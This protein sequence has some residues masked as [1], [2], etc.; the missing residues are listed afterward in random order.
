MDAAE[1]EALVEA[2]KQ[3]GL[4]RYESAVYLGLLMDETAKVSEI[5]KRTGVPQPKA[6]Q[7]LDSLVEKGFCTLG[8]DAI[9][10]Y[11]PVPPADALEEHRAELRR[12]EARVKALAEQLEEIRIAGQGRELWAPPIEII[13]GHPQVERLVLAR[14]AG[15]AEEILFFGKRP[16]MP[17]VD[18]SEALEAF[19]N[20]G[21]KLRML[22]EQ[23]FLDEPGQEREAEKYRSLH[24]DYRVVDTLPSKMIIFDRQVSI[25]SITH[26][27]G[28][29]LDLVLRHPGFVDHF[30][31]SFERYWSLGAPLAVR[32]TA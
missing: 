30:V 3:V 28:R 23:A 7:A 14:I 19:A 27:G 6:Y 18:I 4:G 17:G 21:G 2:L 11:R 13:K 15:A 10:R 24:A 1:Q 16:H 8:S 9:N 5:S 25:S 31:S 29:N 32:S 22:V 20:R 26:S 12:T